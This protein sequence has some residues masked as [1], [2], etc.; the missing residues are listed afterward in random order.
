MK[1]K[2]VIISLV[3]LVFGIILGGPLV[4][5][6][7]V[8]QS[9]LIGVKQDPGGGFTNADLNGTSWFKN[10]SF[11]NF[12]TDSPKA[13][14]TYGTVV[15]DGNGNWTGSATEFDSD[16]TTVSGVF[17]GTYSVNDEGSYDFIITGTPPESDHT[18][19][20]HISRDADRQFSVLS[21]GEITSGNIHQGI[22]TALREPDSPFAL[23]DLNGTWFFRDLEIQDLEENFRRAGACT[24]I[25]V[26]NNPNW[27]ADYNCYNSDETTDTGMTTGTYTLTENTF[28]LFETG[29]PEVLFSTYL[30]R[31]RSILIFTRGSSSGGN[32]EQYIGIALKESAKVFTNA[33]LSGTYFFHDL[34]FADFETNNRELSI[35]VGTITFDGTGNWT[36]TAESFDSDGSS[37]SDTPSGTYSVNSDGSFT[38]VVTSE[39]PNGTLTGN[40]SYDNNT[41]IMSQRE[42]VSIGKDELAVD[43]D[44]FGMWHYNGSSWTNLA[45][46]DPEGMLEWDGGLAVDFPGYGLWN[47]DG[48]T[49]TSLSGWEIEKGVVWDSGVAVDFG[50][51]G[52]W[53]YD[54]SNW[55]MLAGWDPD[56][57]MVKRGTELAVDF[58]TYGLWNYDGISWTSLAG[59]D[60]EDMI[61]VD[62]Y[63]GLILNRRSRFLASFR[64]GRGFHEPC[65]FL[66]ISQEYEFR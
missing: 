63:Q 59:W 5:K 36:A 19:T 50:T 56:S 14:I 2:L 65:L 15:F 22:V 55:T 9:L 57:N 6:G 38:L 34:F 29:D 13:N 51:Y 31:D 28:N 60:P 7:E 18:L 41:V 66:K 33:D 21:E 47:Y 48:T 20:G 26:F 4:A 17:N 44:T 23:G 25:F 32:I 43:F 10:L 53:N 49:W 40:I 1:K 12:E 62:L 24:A 42:N 8:V 27:S 64:E 37:G 54:G 61:D 35:T 3:F 52:L 11:E 58:G 45:G 39:I 46:W 16:G 30:S